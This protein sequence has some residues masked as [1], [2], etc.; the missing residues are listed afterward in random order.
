MT[1]KESGSKDKGKAFFKEFPKQLDGKR[2]FNCQGY[3]YFQADYSNKRVLTL[4]EIKEIDHFAL[5]LADE[6]EEEEEAATV[7]TLS[8]IHI[9]R[10]RRRG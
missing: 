1:P 2:C 4:K 10:C 7:L 5:E 3:G 9:W 6:E 8:L